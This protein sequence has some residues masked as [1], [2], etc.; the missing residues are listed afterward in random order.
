MLNVN[1]FPVTA[2]GSVYHVAAELEGVGP[3][4]QYCA[5]VASEP[6]YVTDN[7][8]VPPGVHPTRTKSSKP[9]GNRTFGGN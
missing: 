4:F 8:T 1:V 3:Y 6:G 2:A 5:P 7:E 9:Y